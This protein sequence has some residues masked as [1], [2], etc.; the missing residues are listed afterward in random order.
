MDMD[1][2]AVQHEIGE[3]GVCGEGVKV[4]HGG[5]V[6]DDDAGAGRGGSDDLGRVH[7]ALSSRGQH[8]HWLSALEQCEVWSW[9]EPW[10]WWW[11]R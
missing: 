2:R 10:W 4:A 3:Q 5:A 9:L 1:M 11:W 6:D 8:A 7:F